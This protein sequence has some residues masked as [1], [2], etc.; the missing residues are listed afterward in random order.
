MT[1]WICWIF[2]VRIFLRKLHEP[3]TCQS[4]IWEAMGC[5]SP[6]NCSDF[7]ASD[8]HVQD[9]CIALFLISTRSTH[10]QFS[11]HSGLICRKS[12]KKFS[13]TLS[14]ESPN[15]QITCL[16]TIYT[17]RKYIAT[18]TTTCDTCFVLLLTV[19]LFLINYFCYKEKRFAK[20]EK[21]VGK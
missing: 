8:I 5:W 9:L 13:P 12:N 20:D 14:E 1:I 19:E 6:K 11:D 10:I 15:S 3:P 16:T 18:T 4:L 21:Q 17:C 7:A 2:C